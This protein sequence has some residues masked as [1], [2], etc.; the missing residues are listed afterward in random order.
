MHWVTA[1]ED[2]EADN[3]AD[4]ATKL[5]APAAKKTATDESHRFRVF[6]RLAADGWEFVGHRAKEGR[7]GAEGWLFK[8]RAK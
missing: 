7:S 1:E 8:R 5:K 4:L 2:I 6:N 3:W